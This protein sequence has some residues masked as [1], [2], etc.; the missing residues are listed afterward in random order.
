MDRQDWDV[1]TTHTLI[2]AFFVIMFVVESFSL[3]DYKGKVDV[4]TSKNTTLSKTISKF[5]VEKTKGVYTNSLI[6]RLKP[7]LDP[8]VAMEI[9]QAVNRHSTTYGL[10]PELVI[11]I[12]REESGFRPTAIS[13]NGNDRGLMGI[14]ISVHQDKVDKLGLKDFEVFYIDNN[15]RLGCEILRGHIDKTETLSAA[16]KGYVGSNGDN[17]NKYINRIIS[18]FANSMIKGGKG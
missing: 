13:R 14:N 12:I 2:I 1:I 7:N 5:E 4:L 17:R 9:A 3:T 18:G 8:T 15:I 16:L 6:K 10:P 11:F